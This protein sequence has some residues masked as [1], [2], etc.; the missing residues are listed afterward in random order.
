[1]TTVLSV[2]KDIICI[3]I[4]VTR[5]VPQDTSKKTFLTEFVLN[6]VKKIVDNVIRVSVLLVILDL[7]LILLVEN[8][9]VK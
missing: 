6:V 2:P 5:T 1:M 9:F 3:I 8:V 4:H 7:K